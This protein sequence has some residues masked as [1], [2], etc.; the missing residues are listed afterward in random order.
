MTLA[1]GASQAFGA[2]GVEAEPGGPP[3]CSVV[4]ESPQL[5]G[6]GIDFW[7]QC[8]YHVSRAVITSSNRRL[9]GVSRSPELV[10]AGPGDAMSCRTG[11]HRRIVC[12][13]SLTAFA[14]IHAQIGLEEPICARPHLRLSVVTTG[15]PQC[16]GNCPGIEFRSVAANAIGK[17]LLGCHGR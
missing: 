6:V 15:G 5:G 17:G 13:G 2:G 3:A 7:L 8:N 10:G 14:R 4:A 1:L 9:S 11:R 12:E 16:T